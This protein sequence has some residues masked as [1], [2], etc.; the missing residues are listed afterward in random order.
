MTSSPNL[1]FATF[2]QRLLARIADYCILG[3]PITIGWANY[4]PRVGSSDWP[5]D[6][7]LVV[8]I[9]FVL[10]EIL[11]IAFLGQTLGKRV[12]G[13]AVIGPGGDVPG[14][15]RSLVR[16]LSATAL[17]IIPF[18]GFFVFGRI[19]WDPQR[20]GLHDKLAGTWV[21]VARKSNLASSSPTV[22]P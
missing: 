2:W 4:Q 10:Y 8:S 12:V 21:I 1:L 20:Q 15:R 22:A 5:L 7:L 14:L 19:I 11:L 6:A 18:L 16:W 3:L 17:N 13:I 9:G